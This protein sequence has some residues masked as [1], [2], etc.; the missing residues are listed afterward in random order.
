MLFDRHIVCQA[1]EPKLTMQ[2][3]KQWQI[4]SPRSLFTEYVNY[5]GDQYL[6]LVIIFLN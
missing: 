6:K 2:L 3:Q 5:S 1:F 4:N